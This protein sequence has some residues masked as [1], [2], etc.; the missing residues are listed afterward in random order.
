MSA[1]A[2][3]AADILLGAVQLT[4]L[5]NDL[6]RAYQAGQMTDEQVVEFYKTQ[7]AP[8]TKLADQAWEDAGKT[9]PPA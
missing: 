2:L 8:R 7:I 5:L 9:A 4:K 1:A 3:A 6:L